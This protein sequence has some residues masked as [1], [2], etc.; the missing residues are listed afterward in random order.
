MR[1]V[2][3][4]PLAKTFLEITLSWCDKLA[5]TPTVGMKFTQN[6]VSSGSLLD[7]ISPI[8][9]KWVD[10]EKAL[11]TIDKQDAFSVELTTEDGFHFGI[12]SARVSVAFVHRLKLK[13]QSGSY[14]AVEMI[15]HPRPYTELLPD[16]CERLLE[17]TALLVD[18][19]SR[20][21]EQIGI[22]STTYVDEKDAPPG[23]LRFIRHVTEPWNKD[24]DAYGF[25]VAAQLKE[26]HETS[27]RCIHDIAR[28]EHGDGLVTLKFDWQRK[29][30][31]ENLI[32][33]GTRLEELLDAA[34]KDALNYFEELA[35]GNRFHGD[36][37]N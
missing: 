17:A 33:T 16:V 37:N 23:I 12:D 27:D 13:N 28:A 8:L 9:D 26:D 21:L 18:A 1:I 35:E 11:F 15:S 10:D 5:S 34:R 31:K 29:F 30:K 36:I 2:F 6:F 24:L 32:P 4:D 14:P 22:V 20:F 3:I 19:N 25:Q 7:T